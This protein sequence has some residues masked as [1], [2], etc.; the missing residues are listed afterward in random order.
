MFEKATIRKNIH[1]QIVHEIA[2]RIIAGEIVPGETLPTEDVASAEMNVSRTAYREALKVL[3]AKGLV[4]SRPKTGTRICPRSQWNLLDPDL[5]SWSFEIGP[6]R[7][8]AQSLSEMR[9]IIEPAAAAL[10]AERAGDADITKIRDA[11]ERMESF[12]VESR[13][14]IEA[15]LDFHLSILNAAGNELLASLGHL[16]KSALDKSFELTTDIPGAREISL[17]RHA[18][19]FQAIQSR[20]PEQASKKMHLLLTE[21]WSDLALAL[22]KN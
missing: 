21:A 6:S 4:K 2:S 5:M 11:L 3:T 13:E 10:A 18:D 17:P 16:I 7:A 1:Q 12:A 19:V 20:Q 15:D 22:E 8:F 9:R 14:S